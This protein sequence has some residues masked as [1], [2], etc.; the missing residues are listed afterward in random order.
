MEGPTA[1][2]EDSNK[3]LRTL[4]DVT[5]PCPPPEVQQ[6]CKRILGSLEWRTAITRWAVLTPTSGF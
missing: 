5:D 6:E 3:D 1:V 2:K 4:D